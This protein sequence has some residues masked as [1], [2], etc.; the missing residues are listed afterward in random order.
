MDDFL[1]PFSLR[2]DEAEMGA[3]GSMMLS[4]F[5]AEQVLDMLSVEDFGNPGHRVLF[6]AIKRVAE[7]G[8]PMDW[9]IVKDELMA[10]N[11]LE[12]MGGEAYLYEVTEFVPSP[13]N[14]GYYAGIVSNLAARRRRESAARKIIEKAYDREV[15]IEQIDTAFEKAIESKPKTQD[16]GLIGLSEV[17]AVESRGIETGF[18]KSF[19]SLTG[20][21]WPCRQV[22]I[23]S[24]PPGIGKT[25][26]MLQSAYDCAKRGLNVGYILAADLS[27]SELRERLYKM[28]TGWKTRPMVS[29]PLGAEWDEA[30]AAVCAM[31]NFYVYDWIKHGSAW[32][33][34]A[35]MIRTIHAKQP[36]DILFVDYLQELETTRRD[37]RSE[38]E[39]LTYIMKAMGKFAARHDLAIVTGSQ[40]TKMPD[41]TFMTK[42][43]RTLEEK[44]AFIV[45][46]DQDGGTDHEIPAAVY[47]RK[48]RLG[49]HNFTLAATFQVK[50]LRWLVSAS[51]KT[52]T[53]KATRAKKPDDYDPYNDD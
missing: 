17:E 18:G 39:Q 12:N 24:A 25:N 46:L 42:G 26:F 36:F 30:T 37:F 22:S 8:K 53:K 16:G 7:A 20:V 6:S 52:E 33:T 28:A 13:A 32:E 34:M 43:A 9:V 50:H 5:A 38:T 35:A 44:A 3:L 29:L 11:D 48:N 19:D 2:N 40:L 45:K 15:T 21:G 27:P 47:I 49:P 10:H 1:N 14:S 41:G 31:K 4:N 51:H 23:V